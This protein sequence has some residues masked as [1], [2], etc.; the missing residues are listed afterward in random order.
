M[1]LFENLDFLNANTLRNFPLKEGVSKTDTSGF[2]V[3]PDD[4][5]VDLILSISADPALRVSISRIVNM[6]DVIE[7][8]LVTFGSTTV[9]GTFSISVPDHA[10]YAEYYLTPSISATNATGKLV[11]G[12]VSSMLAMPY[13]TF[14]FSYS[15][16][17]FEA[18]TII[19][20][21]STISRFVF[22]NADG[23]T[24]SLSGDVTLLAQTN[25]KFRMVNSSTAA[26][27]AGDNLGLNSICGDTRP[28]LKT[29]NNVAPD[30]NGNFWLLT[31]N[32]AKF[33]SLS[34]GTLNGLNLDDT[35]CKP[36][37]SC[38][39]IGDLTERLMQL[40]SDLLAL[41]NYYNQISLVTQQF[42]NL[43]TASCECS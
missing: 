19:P 14:N 32:C 43:S 10:R 9:L 4:F 27:D 11:V 22:K 26:I 42:G 29:I 5:L 18:R 3:I 16:T 20:G 41:R 17:E 8:E 28:C 38:N 1:P 21:L 30:V 15:N 24:F 40:E 33:T 39:E 7:V 23:T 12:E 2:F 13:G 35:C 6:P 31:S 36:C 34:T 25:T 37:L